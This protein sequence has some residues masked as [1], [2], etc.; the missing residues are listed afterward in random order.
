[1]YIEFY[2]PKEYYD[3]TVLGYRIIINPDRELRDCIE[4]TYELLGELEREFEYYDH[5][6][7]FT[8][9]K[10]SILRENP[11]WN[12]NVERCIDI[13]TE[14]FLLKIK[15]RLCIAAMEEIYIHGDSNKKS[16]FHKRQEFIDYIRK[17]LVTVYE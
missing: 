4:D 11:S 15:I 3:F 17:G 2:K 8:C 1:M 6:C 13:A 5:E 16:C 7:L 10:K 12:I 14:L 9:N